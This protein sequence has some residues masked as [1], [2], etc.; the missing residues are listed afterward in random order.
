MSRIFLATYLVFWL[1]CGLAFANDDF[2]VIDDVEI[3]SSGKSPSEAKN[4]AF[5]DSRRKGLE[6]LFSKMGLDP[7]VLE[8]FSDEDL[9]ETIKS[10]QVKSE[11]IAG[12]NYSAV[13]KITYDHNYINYLLK[14]KKLDSLDLEENYIVLSVTQI[15]DDYLLWQS[16]NIWKK[17]VEEAIE[18]RIAPESKYKLYAV[19]A[20]VE[21]MATISREAISKKDFKSLAPTLIKYN[22]KGAYIISYFN[23]LEHKKITVDVHLV[24]KLQKKNIRFS[25]VNTTSIEENELMSKVATKTI[26]YLLSI[27]GKKLRK[28]DSNVKEI[29]ISTGS[30]S[31]W[32]K[33]KQKIEDSGL[34]SD[35]VI[36]SISKERAVILVKYSGHTPDLALRLREIGLDIEQVGENNFQIDN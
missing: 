33:V 3:H 7:L 16:E 19:N 35:L 20:D 13:F 1:A 8:E 32:L 2:Y 34:I 17:A 4:T 23:D 11:I 10:E 15:D 5:D 25:F 29:E 22:A 9:E 30:Y 36:K 28:H 26:D 21:N 18:N 31:R 6:V 14:Q 24:K 27:N 12:N